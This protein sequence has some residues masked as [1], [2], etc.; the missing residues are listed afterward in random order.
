M[1]TR[2]LASFVL[3]FALG[4]AE[5]APVP[6]P[7]PQPPVEADLK[8]LC[9]EKATVWALTGQAPGQ[10]G[11]RIRIERSPDGSVQAGTLT[12]VHRNGTVDAGFFFKIDDSSGKRVL[13]ASGAPFVDRGSVGTIPYR[14]E[15][16]VL[17]LDG[18]RAF[19]EI[20]L[21]GKWERVGQ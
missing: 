20:D 14:L 4:A 17:Y 6:Q 11:V 2:C 8:A 15:K 19:G 21:K 5:A 16:G 12:L 9:G 1:F 10:D 18:G 3:L 7:A 13:E